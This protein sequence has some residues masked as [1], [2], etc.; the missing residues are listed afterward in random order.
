M[1]GGQYE[2]VIR[3][4]LGH[5]FTDSFDDMEVRAS[6]PDGTCLVGYFEDQTA[7]QRFLAQLGELG[8]ELSGV[9]RLSSEE[10]Q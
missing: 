8:L 9:R 3:G 5:T 10:V 7:L 6:D 1:A 4:R 2:I